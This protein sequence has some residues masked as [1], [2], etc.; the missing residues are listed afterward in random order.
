M[1]IQEQ[2][3]WH[4]WE[5]WLE[6]QTKKKLHNFSMLH[7]AMIQVQSQTKLLIENH[8][9][10]RD[11]GTDQK[12]PLLLLSSKFSK[13]PAFLRNKILPLLQND[14][15]CRYRDILRIYT[16]L[17]ILTTTPVLQNKNQ[18]KT[19]KT[20]VY[21]DH[22]IHLSWQFV[23]F[24]NLHIYTQEYIYTER[25]VWLDSMVFSIEVLSK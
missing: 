1:E 23:W 25:M 12:H 22:G 7:I 20:T 4:T 14:K 15:T 17:L 8:C 10:S 13:S 16:A 3:P 2:K 9:L 24:D 21:V 11:K 5:I 6:F 19:K 18:N